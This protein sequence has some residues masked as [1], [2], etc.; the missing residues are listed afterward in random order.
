MD[1]STII[2][3]AVIEAMNVQSGAKP[4]PLQPHE[5]MALIQRSG[6][7][8]TVPPNVSYDEAIQTLQHIQ[9][10]ENETTNFVDVVLGSYYDAAYAFY[11]ALQVEFGFVF[12]SFGEAKSLE[13]GLAQRV[14]LP[15]GGFTVPGMSGQIV[16]GFHLDE[17]LQ[18]VYFKAINKGMLRKDEPRMKKLMVTTREL[19]ANESI[20][21]GQA[22]RVN[23]RDICGDAVKVPEPEFI[24]TRGGS[25]PEALILPTDV[26]AAVKTSIFAPIQYSAEVK[27]A[28]I[29]L[30]RGVLLAGPY[31]TG[32]SLTS[33]V[34]SHLAVKHGWTFIYCAQAAELKACLDFAKQYQPA[35]VFCEDIDRSMSGDGRTATM[36]DVLNTID[37]I[38]SKTSEIMIVLTTNHL[39]DLNQALLR[40]G[41]LD[42][43]IEFKAPDAAAAA[44]LVA[45]YAKGRLEDGVNLL[46]VGEELKGNIPAVV[47]EIVERA[48]L[49][50]LSLSKGTSTTLSE[51]S[52]IESARTMRNQ[53]ELLKPRGKTL[54]VGE[55]LAA[56]LAATG[57]GAGPGVLERPVA[58]YIPD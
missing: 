32:K 29:P 11:K 6:E 36:D 46:N 4:K 5:L 20:Y 45:L 51:H 28:G 40:P 24:D 48:K 7:K 31:G 25:N 56:G 50:A 33:L 41:R 18:R 1:Q 8:I 49:S 39:E 30:K 27:A 53:I 44:K 23:F 2:A 42:A 9:K 14:G 21:K 10:Y 26:D 43:I 3:K 54:T 34:T 13:V 57:T 17:R 12:Q 58:D 38:E 19:L 47:R 15:L 35:V 16:M 37:G 22:V 52:L 55:A